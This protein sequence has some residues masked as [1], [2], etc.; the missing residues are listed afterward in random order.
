MVNAAAAGATLSELQSVAGFGD[1]SIT[2]EP[3]T[4][5]RA[6]EEF[7]KLRIAAKV[8]EKSGRAPF[9]HQLNM[10]PSRRYRIR[11]DWTS[12]FFQVGGLTVLN[13]KDFTGIAD[14]LEALKK[15]GSSVAVITSDD[16]TYASTVVDL[17]KAINAEVANVTVLVAGAPGENE[18]AW[19]DAGVDDF[20]NVRVN[21]YE[22]NRGLL[23]SMGAAL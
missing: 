12:S 1:V 2:A 11:A 7:E 13:E 18:V 3:I 17:A 22:F 21:N 14:A 9:V 8:M 15:S 6:A 16:E 23:E 4:L 19:R 10:G 20:V 5:K